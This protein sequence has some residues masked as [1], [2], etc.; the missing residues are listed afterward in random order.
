MI[1]YDASQVIYLVKA[2]VGERGQRKDGHDHWM[3]ACVSFLKSFSAR[4]GLH[5]LHGLC[6]LWAVRLVTFLDVEAAGI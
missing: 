5:I 3:S 6:R 2:V 1:N 4:F